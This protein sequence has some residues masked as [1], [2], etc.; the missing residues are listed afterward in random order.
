MFECGNF[1]CKFEEQQKLLEKYADELVER[2]MVVLTPKRKNRLK[3]YEKYGLKKDFNG[4]LLIGKDGRLKLWEKY[5]VEPQVLFALVDSMPMR[6]A[7]M[8]RRQEKPN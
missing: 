2:D 8:K 7:E 6:R 4:L 5:V 1:D 3:W